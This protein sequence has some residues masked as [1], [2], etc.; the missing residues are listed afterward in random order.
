MPTAIDAQVAP[1]R[2][3]LTLEHGPVHQASTAGIVKLLHCML[4]LHGVCN[5]LDV[6][7][8]DT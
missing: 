1:P 5:L 6:C 3:R 8:Y 2:G 7:V 4:Q